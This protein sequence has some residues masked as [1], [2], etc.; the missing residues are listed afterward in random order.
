VDGIHPNLAGTYLG[1]YVFY[2]ILAGKSLLGLQ[3]TA[4]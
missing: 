1:A 4:D 3:Y 2:T